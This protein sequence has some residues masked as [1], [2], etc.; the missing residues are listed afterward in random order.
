MRGRVLLFYVGRRLLL[1]IP[2]TLLV[3]VAV[4]LL[5]SLVPGGVVAV[6]LQ[7]HPTNTAVVEALRQKYH[8][9]DPIYIQ[10]IAWLGNVLHG[11]LGRS[12]LTSEPVSYAIM[13][14]LALTVELNAG[15]LLL[16]LC[17]GVPLGIIAATKQGRGRD[18]AVVGVAIFGSSAP[19]FIV[20]LVILYVFAERLALFPLFGTG[21]DDVG[22]RLWHMV[23]PVVSLAIGPLALITK[24]TRASVLDLIERDHVL[25]ARARGVSEFRILVVYVLRNALIPIVTTAGL[26]LIGLL[27]G[28]VF[29]ETIFGLPGLGQL[30]VSSVKGTDIPMIQGLVLVFAIWVVI[31]NVFI[32]IVYVLIDPRVGFERAAR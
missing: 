21:T 1:L 7:G 22:D 27:T 26:L 20:A 3:T 29:V 16:A 9:S 15:G 19:H 24:I 13:S 17:V 5:A 12:V 8:L 31:A 10:Y 14:R 4:F 30:L 2:V 18:R 28:T 6:I 32:D 11:D 23:L 25:F